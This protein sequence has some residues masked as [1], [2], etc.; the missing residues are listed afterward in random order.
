V[1][2]L[3]EEMHRRDKE[4]GMLLGSLHKRGKNREASGGVDTVPVFSK[5]SRQ[6]QQQQSLGASTQLGQTGGVQEPP[7]GASPQLGRANRHDTTSASMAAEQSIASAG[8]AAA[9]SS[10]ASTV[11]VAASN[12][13]AAPAAQ[14]S[15]AL[16][17]DRNKAFEVFRKSVRRSEFMEE[18]KEATKKLV[19]D[20][21]VYG[22]TANVAR[23]AINAKRLQVEKLRM[24]RALESH[25]RDPNA[26]PTEAL[27]DPPEVVTL[28]HEMEEQKRTYHQFTEKLRQVK[29][30][31][32]KYKMLK[33]QN[34]QRLQRDFESWFR[35]REASQGGGVPQ[36]DHQSTAPAAWDSTAT[37]AP[38]ATPGAAGV[39]ITGA[40][41]HAAGARLHTASS[42]RSEADSSARATPAG[43]RPAGV[44]AAV[45]ASPLT[46]QGERPLPAVGAWAPP[47][48][49]QS[50]GSSVPSGIA[51][52]PSGRPLAASGTGRPSSRGAAA[53]VAAP[54][55]SPPRATQPPGRSPTPG[56]AASPRRVVPASAQPPAAAAPQTP[57]GVKLTGDESTDKEIAAYYAALAA[58]T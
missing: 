37:A 35:S 21:K 43:R 50:Q 36:N 1:H 57:A 53:P 4:I 46:N 16:L 44:A 8:H 42:M 3:R 58:L 13:Q 56:R 27:A 20:A 28:L 2:E 45:T 26:A 15:A 5:G 49:V 18:N 25:P 38:V 7:P 33:E 32:D 22:E 54:S 41:S 39:A 9:S 17:L 47:P 12:P 48:D 14:D 11:T 29:S 30:E 31:I 10:S 6:Q 19:Q 51:R 40:S 52:P 24:A 23:A 34:Q 55:A